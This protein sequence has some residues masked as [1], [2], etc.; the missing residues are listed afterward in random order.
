MRCLSLL[1]RFDLLHIM[2]DEPD[3]HHDTEIAEHILSV[4]QGKGR[5]VNPPYTMQAMQRFIKYARAIKPKLTELVSTRHLEPFR[6]TQ[7]H[8]PP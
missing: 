8:W 1:P 7:S 5:A 2:I 4:H 3:E 6:L